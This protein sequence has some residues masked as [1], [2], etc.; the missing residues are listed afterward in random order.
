MIKRN[1]SSLG[2]DLSDKT[3]NFCRMTADGGVV[4]EGKVA[5]TAAKVAELW[6]KHG[7]VDVIVLESGT[8]STWV[9]DL[10]TT[11]GARVIVADPRKLRAV[12]DSVRKSD[13][14]DA[15]MLARI[16]LADEDLLSPTYVR[17]PE[18]RKAM[19]LLKVR[20]QQVRARTATVLEIRSQVK[21]AGSRMPQCDAR[22][23]HE[24]EDAVPA[25][26]HDALAPLFLTLRTL[27]A[28]VAALDEQI[29]AVGASFPIVARL[30][31][32]DGVGPIT[33][34]AFVAVIGDPSRFGKTRDIGAYLGL[35]PRRDQSGIADPSRR[36][37]KAGSG[38]LRRLLVQ[39]AQTV[40]RPRGKDTAQRRWAHRQLDLRGKP[41]KRKIVVAVARKLAVVLLSLW[42]SGEPWTPLHRVAADPAVDAPQPVGFDEC[43]QASCASERVTESAPSSTTRTQPCTG[44]ES[45]TKSADGSTG[46]SGASTS[47][48]QRPVKPSPGDVARASAPARSAAPLPPAALAGAGHPADLAPTARARPLARQAGLTAE[49]V[50]IEPDLEQNR[51]PARSRR[52]RS[53]DPGGDRPASL[54][55]S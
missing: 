2:I 47:G 17:P 22:D 10:L 39:C 14:R 36:I 23:F 18:L 16:G 55:G 43:D 11:L 8:P 44:S 40:C 48:R 15:R 12:T 41:G 19:T 42:K 49:G 53:E 27:D 30:E 38:F 51:P 7:D 45:P 50:H 52:L 46:R 5:L 37:S 4:A 26:L 35:V 20:D 13:E 24:H 54:A 25:E 3:A 21:L 31:K 29:K 1:Q 34:L 9:Q 6:R 32:V 28:V 33:A